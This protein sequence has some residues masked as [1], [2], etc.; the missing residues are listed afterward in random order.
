M[1]WSIWIIN[2]KRNKLGSALL[3]NEDS[4]SASKD[5]CTELAVQNKCCYAAVLQQRQADVLNDVWESDFEI[6]NK[7]L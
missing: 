7:W 6:M 3:G 2:L 5:K 1:P 4:S